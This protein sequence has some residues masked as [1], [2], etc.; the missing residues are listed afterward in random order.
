MRLNQLRVGQ[1]KTVMFRGSETHGLDAWPTVS[2]AVNKSPFRT[3][4][5]A[6]ACVPTERIST[7]VALVPK[8]VMLGVTPATEYRTTEVLKTKVGAVP[9]AGWVAIPQP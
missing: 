2:E 1:L 8:S 7:T 5:V 4:P 9:Q 6:P 3:V